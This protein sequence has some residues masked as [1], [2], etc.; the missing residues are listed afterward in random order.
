MDEEGCWDGDTRQGNEEEEGG[1]MAGLGATKFQHDLQEGMY[2][3]VE[4]KTRCVI[5]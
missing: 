3:R 4:R 2:A 5:V 1:C